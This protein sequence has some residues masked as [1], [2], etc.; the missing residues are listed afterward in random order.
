MLFG[1]IFLKMLYF[2][3]KRANIVFFM[4]KITKR[5]KRVIYF[6]KTKNLRNM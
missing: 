2:A 3:K 6:K 1:A 5:L 4:C